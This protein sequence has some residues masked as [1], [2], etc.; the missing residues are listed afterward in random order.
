MTAATQLPTLPAAAPQ[1][2]W[3]RILADRP[4]YWF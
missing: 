4:L 2:R 3:A 1:A